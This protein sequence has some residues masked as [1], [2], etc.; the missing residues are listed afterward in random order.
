MTACKHCAMMCL[1]EEDANETT[2]ISSQ[3]EIIL[4]ELF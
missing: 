1:K 3:I 4:A 2:K